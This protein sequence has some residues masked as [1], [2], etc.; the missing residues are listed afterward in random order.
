KNMEG[1]PP[2][3]MFNPHAHHIVFKNGNGA[4]QQERK[5]LINDTL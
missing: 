1:P 3:D 5:R 4:V 2:E